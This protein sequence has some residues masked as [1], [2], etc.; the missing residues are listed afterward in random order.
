MNLCLLL[1]LWTELVNCG[2]WEKSPFVNL[3]PVIGR[4]STRFL[5][6]KLCSRLIIMGCDF[7]NGNFFSFIHLVSHFARRQKILVLDYLTS[8]VTNKLGV[9]RPILRLLQGLLLVSRVGVGGIYLEDVM[10]PT[11]MF[12]TCWQRSMPVCSGKSG[13]IWSFQTWRNFGLTYVFRS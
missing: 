8:G 1:A 11:F 10:T 3:S 4:M 5:W 13:R 9:I 12:G 7:F 6:V 2:I